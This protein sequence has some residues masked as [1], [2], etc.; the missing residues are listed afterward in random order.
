M[1][2]GGSLGGGLY[3]EWTNNIKLRIDFLLW[4]TNLELPVRTIV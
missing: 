4:L 1:Q 3:V 2:V